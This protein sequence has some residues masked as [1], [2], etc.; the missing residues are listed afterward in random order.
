MEPQKTQNRQSNPEELKPRVGITLPDFRQYYKVTAIKIEWYW[1]QNRHTDQWNRIANPEISPD[2]YGRLI[3]GKGGKN[4]KREKDS[5]AGKI[6]QLKKQV[7]LGKS[8]SCM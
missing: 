7:M 8:N 4:I 6:K 2:S 1:Y 5:D 3:F